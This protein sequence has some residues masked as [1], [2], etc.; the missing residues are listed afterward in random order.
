MGGV[1]GPRPA[2]AQIVQVTEWVEILLPTRWA[3]IEGFAAVQLHAGNDKVQ[4]MV[5]GVAVSYPQNIALVSV[6]SGEGHGFKIVHDPLF[7]LRRHHIIGMPREHPSGETPFGLQGV[8]E[9]ARCFHI[10]AQHLRW[11]LHTPRVIHTHK[12]ARWGIAGICRVAASVGKN[13][14]IHVA[15][16]LT[17]GLSGL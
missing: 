8:D 3:G 16:P 11:M 2:L 13:L 4:F 7:L 5:P 12:V 10:T 15:S 1:I 17:N 9:R 14:H 6:Q